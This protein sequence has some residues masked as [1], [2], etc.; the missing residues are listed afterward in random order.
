MA[1]RRA[2]LAAATAILLLGGPR[3]PADDGQPEPTKKAAQP[4][5]PPPAGTKPATVTPAEQARGMLREALR[6]IQSLADEDAKKER[7]LIVR[8]PAEYLTRFTK[9][10]QAD[11]LRA[12]GHAQARLGDMPAARTNWQAALDASATPSNLDVSL[13]PVGERHALLI[14]VIEAQ[15]E[16]GERDEVRFTIRQ[17][18]QVARTA[19]AA[20]PFPIDL[21]PGMEGT[22]DQPVKK[23][24]FLARIGQ[25]QL[26]SGDAAGAQE[27][28]RQAL[29]AAGSI[30]VPQN[31]VRSLLEIAGMGPPEK[32]DVLWAEALQLALTQDE[33]PRAQGVESVLRGQVEIGRIDTAL[34]TLDDRLKGDLRSFGL[35]SVADAIAAGDMAVRPESI[36]RLYQLAVQAE[37]D[38][39]S[40]RF[41]TFRRIAEA[42]ARLGAYDAA[43]RTVGHPD[44]NNGGQSFLAR[45]ARAYV[46]AAVARAQLRAGQAGAVKD[47]GHAALELIGAQPDDEGV[48]RILP[49]IEVS[50]LLAQA[51]DFDGALGAAD[52]VS[53]SSARVRILANTAVAQARAGRRDDARKTLGRAAAAAG[54]T[55]NETL[56]NTAT[57]TGGADHSP[58]DPTPAAHQTVALAQ[59][60][61]GELD[62]AFKTIAELRTGQFANF[63]RKAAVEEVIDIRLEA[64]DIAGARRALELISPSDAMFQDDKADLL[65]RIARR[66]AA[67]HDAATILD[68]ARKESTPRAK[69]RLLQGLAE[70]LA[71]RFDPKAP[72]AAPFDPPGLSRPRTGGP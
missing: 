16:A 21:P 70:G 68:W 29:D 60:T 38:R 23:A 51:G 35:W 20:S 50:D 46:M 49:I 57:F 2:S 12:I 26:K 34:A 14:G 19:P 62:A 59:A 40:K 47:T 6:L 30:K 69:I 64:D 54:A 5:S 44:P 33:Y 15:I 41:K 1:F 39:P 3:L 17:A 63:L 43:Y 25:L 24:S 37:F 52:T 22:A 72:P 10:Q 9:A 55:P 66:Q 45:Q 53:N 56:W 71:D 48:E 67:R 8:S 36:E 58:L 32:A 11:V 18:L 27:T 7:Q 65:E 61:V 28:M 31:K 13:D 42:Q 4:P